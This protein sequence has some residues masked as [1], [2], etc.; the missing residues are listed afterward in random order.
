[1]ALQFFVQNIKYAHSHESDMITAVTAEFI[2][3]CNRYSAFCAIK[4][5]LF[6]ILCQSNPIGPGLRP[7]KHIL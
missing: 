5:T 1:M 3:Q 7:N 2:R 6:E 4:S